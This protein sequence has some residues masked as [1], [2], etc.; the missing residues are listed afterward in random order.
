MKI[1]RLIE[2][3]RDTDPDLLEGIPQQR[4]VALIEKVFRHIAQTV[5]ITESDRVAYEG[6]GRFAI[7]QVT[8]EVDGKMVTLP[9][10][11][12]IRALPNEN[13]GRGAGSKARGNASS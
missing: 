1:S 12:F 2:E 11:R 10:V 13:K 4:A 7:K 3:I 8:K 9:R 6:L 5:A